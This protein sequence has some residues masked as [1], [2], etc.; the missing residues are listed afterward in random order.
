MKRPYL[1]GLKIRELQ[2][3]HFEDLAA[4]S[5]SRCPGNCAYNQVVTLGDSTIRI[6]TAGQRPGL[7]VDTHRIVLCQSITQAM[8]CRQYEP[9]FVTKGDVAAALK[10]EISDP[11]KKKAMFPDIAALEWVLD[12]DFHEATQEPNWRVSLLLKAIK[13]FERLVKWQ[14]GKQ[15]L[16]TWE[17]KQEV[18]QAAKKELE[19]PAPEDSGPA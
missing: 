3:K 1:V 9:K 2:K 10:A 16:L 6:C 7:P 12:N 4:R 17:K 18:A 8:E 19:P 14:G 5:L 15:A 13:L 11:Y